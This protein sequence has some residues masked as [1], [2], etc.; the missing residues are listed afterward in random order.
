MTPLPP[1]LVLSQEDQNISIQFSQVGSETLQ[2][3]VGR[4]LRALKRLPR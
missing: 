2:K 4:M 3:A 1:F